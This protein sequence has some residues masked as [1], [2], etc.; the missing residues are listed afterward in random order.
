MAAFK[1]NLNFIKSNWI[2][3]NVFSLNSLIDWVKLSL[4]NEAANF[5]IMHTG[6]LGFNKS[7]REIHNSLIRHSI[8]MK[9]KP[10][11]IEFNEFISRNWFLNWLGLIECCCSWL[12]WN[13]LRQNTLSFQFNQHSTK[14][15]YHRNLIRHGQHVNFSFNLQKSKLL[16]SSVSFQHHYYWALASLCTIILL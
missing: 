1:Q 8:F 13:S 2:K 14:P 4:L 3:L 6:W 10:E 11:L 15:I 5:I 16:I 12:K 7:M 9:L